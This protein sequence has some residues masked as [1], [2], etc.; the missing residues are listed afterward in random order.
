MSSGNIVERAVGDARKLH[1]SVSDAVG[2]AALEM[3]PKIQDSIE[4]AER[5]Q[6]A[7]SDH[8]AESAKISADGHKAMLGHLSAIVAMG[9]AAIKESA[10]QARL[11]AGKMLDETSALYE[12]AAGIAGFNPNTAFENEDGPPKRTML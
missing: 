5:M 7:L 11:T 4:Q 10:E 1:Q 6:Q 9:Q 3:K 12:T 2:R 8:A